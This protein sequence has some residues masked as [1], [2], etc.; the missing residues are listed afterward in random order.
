MVHTLEHTDP[1]GARLGTMRLTHGEVETPIFMPVGTLATVKALT[2]VDLHQIGAQICLANTYHLH[3]RPGVEIIEEHGGLHAM[4]GWERPILTDSGGFQ[5][6][7]LRERCKITEEGVA[8]QSHLDGSRHLFTP[9]S[10]IGI[11]ESLGSD[12]AM[13]FDECPP[14]TAP[15]AA[16]EA[17]MA[18]T[19]RWAKRCIDARRREDQA[20]FGIIQGGLS[21]KHRAAHVDEIC[22]LPFDGFAIGGLSVGESTEELHALTAYTA[23]RMPRDHVR[24]L[25]GVGTP[26]NLL[27]AIGAGVDIFDCVLPTRDARTGKL[28]TRD[29]DLNIKNSRH[30]HSMEPI[31][32]E[33]TC[34]ACAT[35]TR[36]Y[37]RHLHQA[38]EILFARMATLHNLT[39]YLTLMANAR[40]AI[41]ANQYTRWSSEVLARRAAGQALVRGPQSAR[42]RS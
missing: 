3:L 37:L 24:Y 32:A 1:D 11:Q 42:Q 10:V 16:I 14:S 22:S 17:S 39:F 7:S 41:R 12:I 13:A 6:F 27:H 35:F 25:M 40:D 23:P 20:V 15:I 28:F 4:M 19:T 9:E 30:A 21:E 5:V 34:Y 33:C 26:E 38:K 31:D 2:P 18:R 29:G 36:A 8:F